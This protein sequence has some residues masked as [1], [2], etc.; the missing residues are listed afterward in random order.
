[1]SVYIV[2]Y[3]NEGS[4]PESLRDAIDQGEHFGSLYY[5]GSIHAFASIVPQ[6]TLFA[7]GLVGEVGDVPDE[8]VWLG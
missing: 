2:V 4:T 1:M 7:L 8:Q 3:D 6:H 5:R